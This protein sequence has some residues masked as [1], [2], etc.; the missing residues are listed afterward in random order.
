MVNKIIMSANNEFLCDF[1]FMTSF[2]WHSYSYVNIMTL[3]DLH[4]ITRFITKFGIH[5]KRTDR[6]HRCPA[7]TNEIPLSINILN[8]FI[9]YIV[10]LEVARN[11]LTC[12]L[13]FHCHAIQLFVLLYLFRWRWREVS[14]SAFRWRRSYYAFYWCFWRWGMNCLVIFWI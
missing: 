14:I 13:T 12:F 3:H 5:I 6:S 1:I 8:C 4:K 2:L 10:E 7:N 9:T 11:A